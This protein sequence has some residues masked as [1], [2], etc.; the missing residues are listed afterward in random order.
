MAQITVPGS[1]HRAQYHSIKAEI[2][3]A[4]ARV[5]D[6]YTYVMNE[7]VWEFE[8]TFAAYCD[9]KHAVAVH[10]G[11][12][13][14]LISLLVLGIGPGDEVI[15]A[16]NGCPSVP[17]A[18]SHTGATPVFADIDDR[19]FNIDPA[20]LEAAITAK[21]R[22]VVPIHSYG[23]PYDIKVIHEIAH[24][25]GVLVI[26]DAS[27]AAGAQYEGQRVGGFGDV[28]IFSLGHGKIL[29]ALG[30]AGIIVTDHLDMVEQAQA[31]R[32]YG[33]RPVQESDGIKPEYLGREV[34]SA[35]SGYNSRMDAIQAA[36]LSVKLRKLDE[37]IARRNEIAHRYDRLL[38][39]LDVVRPLVS[40]NVIS[41][42]RGYTIL[43]TGRDRVL[44]ELR[45]RGIG[46]GASYLPPL[47]MHPRWRALGYHE[48]DFPVTEMVAREMIQLPLYPE[49]TDEQVEQV[50][51]ALR[52]YLSG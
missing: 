48:G 3:S 25:H 35:L 22:A 16:N 2:D 12:D 1:N 20:S 30:S 47:H 13:A 27:L 29:N 49:L 50:V 45:A 6:G 52:S 39:D 19:T 17:V 40:D 37:W 44:K 28:G 31:Y 11:H 33:F 8:K 7:H 24:R 34:V 9:V 46:A 38:A 26:E 51:A 41:A 42:Y 18:I 15:T 5:L 23:Q 32:Q 14:I 21:T 4:I 10:S 43:V 36:V